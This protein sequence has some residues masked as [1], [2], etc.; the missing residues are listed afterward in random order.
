[1]T[2]VDNDNSRH[3]PRDRG[4]S[5]ALAEGI[6]L[7]VNEGPVGPIYGVC[8]SYFVVGRPFFSSCMA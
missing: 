5:A 7:T 4:G 2:Q 3:T 6:G 1:M 8:Q